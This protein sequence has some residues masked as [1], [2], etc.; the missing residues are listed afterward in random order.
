MKTL[1]LLALLSLA[2]SA[3]ADVYISGPRTL[4][5]KP[6]T[7]E[8]IEYTLT[9]S[10]TSPVRATIFSNDYTQAPDGTMV[11]APA[12]SLPHSLERFMKFNQTAYVVPAQGTVKVRANVSVP[13]TATGGY[14]GVIGVDAETPAVSA[15]GNAVGIRVRYAMVTA[16]EVTGTMNHDVRIENVA[17]ESGS[18]PNVQVTFRNSGNAYERFTLRVTYQDT[19]GRKTE[20][21]LPSVVLPGTVDLVVAAPPTLAA[22]T[23]AVFVTAEYANGTRAEAVSTVNIVRN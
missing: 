14:W 19:A 1:S 6:G 2:S 7:N 20:T 22:G 12:L 5:L 15:G 21:T 16:L 8:V 10:G 9:N 3:A 23:Y 13:A 17:T 11:H 4:T 18:S